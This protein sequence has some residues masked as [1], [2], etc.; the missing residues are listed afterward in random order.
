[1]KKQCY[2]ILLMVLGLPIL[3]Q[4]QYTQKTEM[5]PKNW[6]F[7]SG[8]D[9]GA[10]WGGTGV[11]PL[12]TATDNLVHSNLAYQ[13]AYTG[14][15][16]F[17]WL[18]RKKKEGTIGPDIGIKTKLVWDYFT[19][20][21]NGSGNGYESLTLNY[22]NIPLLFEYCLSFKNK[23]TAPRYTAPSSNSQS[24]VYDHG[25]YY[26][27][28]TT[29]TYNPGGYS[30][31]GVPFSD[32]IFIYAGPQVCFLTRG[33]HNLNGAGETIDTDP[34]LQKSY[35]G[36]VGG[37]CFYLANINLD[38]SYQKGITSIS[39]VENVYVNGFLFKVGFNLSRRK[40]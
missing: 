27:V 29:T 34:A 35:I 22:A 28:I 15:V 36:L 14:D 6:K 25:Y 21:N 7:N 10:W 1:M 37:F 19:A 40:F 11:S 2:S 12:K 31:G 5:H 18:H 39:S 26:H 20:N 30:P 23:V 3:L 17:E 4:A 24:Y 32:A 16:Y 33:F 13:T 38:F 9:V 8:L